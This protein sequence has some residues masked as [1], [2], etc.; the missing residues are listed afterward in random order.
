M[1]HLE[2]KPLQYI[3]ILSN[4]PIFDIILKIIDF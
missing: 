2:D 3:N 4:Q 1:L